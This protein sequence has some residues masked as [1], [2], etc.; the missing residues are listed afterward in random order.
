MRQGLEVLG[1]HLFLGI[2]KAGISGDP[3]CV[4]KLTQVSKS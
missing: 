1:S 4:A 3:P 2:L